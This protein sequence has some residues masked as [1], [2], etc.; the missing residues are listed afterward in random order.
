MII[1][2]EDAMTVSSPIEQI[3]TRGQNQLFHFFFHCCVCTNTNTMKGYLVPVDAGNRPNDLVMN[4][5]PLELLYQNLAKLEPHSLVV[6]LDA[7]F[8]EV[9]DASPIVIDI[10]NPFV[11][12]DNAVAISASANNEISSW[13]KARDH[14]LFTYFFLKAIRDKVNAIPD[15]RSTSVTIT[16]EDIYEV[17]A[18]KKEGVP[19]WADKLE[20]GRKQHPQI[21]GDN[22]TVLLKLD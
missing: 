1:V 3:R 6:I 8:S 16:A 22:T 5:Y 19:Y 4:A 11:K 21:F 2:P 9:G 7:C 17:V 15:S 14:G 10:I 20:R 18:D 13:F 12:L